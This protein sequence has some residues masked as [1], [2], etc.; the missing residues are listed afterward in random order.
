MSPDRI[1]GYLGVTRLHRKCL[2]DPSSILTYRQDQTDMSHK[3]A[4]AM[5][6][7]FSVES[8]VRGHHVYKT[9]WTPIIGK[10]LCVQ[11]EEHNTFDRFAVAVLKDDVIV[12]HVPRELARTCWFVLQKRYSIMS[13][14]ITGRRRL[15]E[16][17]GEGLVVPCVYRFTGKSKHLEKLN[18]LFA[19]C[20]T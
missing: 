7:S 18:T 14:K 3:Q 6:T 10:D 12:S 2:A 11:I 19:N 1:G 16:V 9:Q 5:A 13:C 17:E 15:S 4:M 8:T 20:E